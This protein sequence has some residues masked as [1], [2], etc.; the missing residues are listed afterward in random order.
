MRH[1]ISTTILL[2]LLTAAG[3]RNYLDEQL[4]GTYSDGT[5]YQ[6][7]A[8]AVLAI[9]A[10]Y[11]PLTFSSDR[12]RLWV[13]GD[14]A[15]DDAAKGGDPGDQADIGL[16]DNFQIFPSNGVI[17][18]QWGELYEGIARC[19]QVLARVPKISNITPAVQTRILGEARFLRA[20]Y[21]FYL[22]NIY[23]PVPLLLETKNADQLQIPQ[24]PVNIIYEQGIEPDLQEAIKN[25]PASHTGGN[26][27]RATKGAATA[28]L[29]KAYLFQQ[30]WQQ[31][32]T[33]AGQV[34]A[35]GNYALLPV[36][37]QNFSQDAKN[38]AEAIF[39][40][41]HLTAQV[42]FTGN[43]LN[44]WFA[45]RP[46]ENGYF[47]NV[48]TQNFVDEFEKTSAGVVDPRLDYTVG[49]AGRL[50]VN[51][52][53]FDPSWSPTGYL[54]KKHVQ[55]LA[56][57]SVATKG[58]G[59]LNYVTLRYAEV[60]L[61]QAEALNE[62]GRTAEALPLLNQVRRRARESY[63]NDRSLSATP[64]VPPGLLPN[65]ANVS[66]SALREAIRHE[67]RVELGFEFHRYF[68]V[69]RYGR[70]YAQAALRDKPQFRYE[71]TRYFPIPQSERDTNK[72]LRF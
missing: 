71:T 65:V 53:A 29:A 15:S 9:N 45:P 2:T 48:P 68:D 11:T 17:E 22:V 33:T 30:K 51:G 54:N 28:L 46:G 44:Q 40:V 58:D 42:P 60:L 10:A 32:A 67:R 34:Q 12:N 21:Y 36:Y 52:E 19:N 3:C 14:V 69:M 62:L 47:F 35:L 55:P 8:Q 39:S 41:Q 31:A 49:R 72:A 26:I 61:I 13:F 37:S 27:G 18:S 64:A 63:L 4:L 38:S 7:E 16:V 20:L 66:Q 43:R 23:G 24:S 50:W 25:L 6:N 5:F 1:I 57:V 59:N 56:E 70:D